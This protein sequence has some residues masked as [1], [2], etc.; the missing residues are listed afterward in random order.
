MSLI[1]SQVVGTELETVDKKLPLLFEREG[2]FYNS[3]EKKRV[4]VVSNRDM[5]IPLGM[6]PG[7]LFGHYNP[8]GGSLGRGDAQTFDKA[9]INCVHLREAMGYTKLAEMATDTSRKAIVDVVRKIVSTA[10][11]EFRRNLD[12]LSMTGG[13]G[14]LG[15]ISAV[16]T[17]GNKDTYTLATA[18]DGFGVKLLRK[19]SRYSVYVANLSARRSFANNNGTAV[20]GEAPIDMYDLENKQVRFSETIAAPAIATDKIVVSGLTATPPVSLL[21]VPYH[22]NNAATGTWLGFDRALTPEIRAN[23]V[24]ASAQLALAHPR[25][26]MNKV[27]D[28]VGMNAGV[29]AVFWMHPC[30]AQQYE[31]LGQLV[32]VI[33]KQA[34]AEGL[35]LYFGNDMQMAGVPVKTHFAWDKTRIDG[36]V[37]DTWGRAEMKSIGFYDVEGR[38]LFEGRSTTDGSVL[39]AN[40]FYVRVSTNLFVDNPAKCVYISGL[41]IPSGY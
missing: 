22:H 6:G 9:V 4:E 26:A 25:L 40:D 10:I 5:R 11:E 13:D 21:G 39:A 18:G 29:K 23:R 30:Q 27:G 36:I 32:S 14:V 35:N 1:E 8:D 2:T 24:T 41:T 28:R 16:A 34:K 17:A 20:G 37:G 3:I 31:S 33:Q 12:A 38:K 15:T 19:G 7:G